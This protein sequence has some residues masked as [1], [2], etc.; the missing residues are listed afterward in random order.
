MAVRTIF[1]RHATSCGRPTLTESKCAV[2]FCSPAP[3][4]PD[5]PAWP[6]IDQVSAREARRPH[7][8]FDVARAVQAGQALLRLLQ[9]IPN[10]R[11]S[12]PRAVVIQLD[13]WCAGCAN[14]PNRFVS[15]LDGNATAKNMAT[16]S[17]TTPKP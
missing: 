7:R 14:C 9:T 2:I 11:P 17:W 5:D 4:T 3:T 10:F 13:A 16:S 12:G 15:E 8:Q 6:T 1:P